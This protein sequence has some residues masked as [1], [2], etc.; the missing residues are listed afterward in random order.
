MG[1]IDQ[2]L[3]VDPDNPQA[4]IMSAYLDEKQK[5]EEK[6]KTIQSHRK[7]VLNRIDNLEAEFKI[8]TD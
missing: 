8:K 7:I 6:L 1:K 5:W 3:A 2:I 4:L